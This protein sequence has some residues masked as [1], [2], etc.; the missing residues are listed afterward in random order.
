[1]PFGAKAKERFEGNHFLCFALLLKSISA[2]HFLCAKRY[3][4]IFWFI[5]P[6]SLKSK[7][8]FCVRYVSYI[9]CLRLG[10]PNAGF[11]ALLLSVSSFFALLLQCHGSLLG[12]QDVLRAQNYEI[13]KKIDEDRLLLVVV[14]CI[15]WQYIR[16]NIGRR[17][18]KKSIG[19]TFKKR[20]GRIRLLDAA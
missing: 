3:C 8:N 1:M 5:F 16:S 13:L 14:T 7:N 20:D 17:R 12:C 18:K 6:G 10:A 9:V 2:I 15:Y 4:W 11:K 19:T